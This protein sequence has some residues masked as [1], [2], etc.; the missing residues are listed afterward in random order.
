MAVNTPHLLTALG[1]VALVSV[2]APLAAYTFPS[3]VGADEA[4]VVLTGSM[5]PTID[6]GDVVFIEQVA[7]EDVEVGD[8]VTFHPHI[9]DERTFTH[10]VVEKAADEEGTRGIVLTTK[11]DANEDPDRTQVN[12]QMLVGKISHVLPAYGK[13]IYGIDNR[14]V[15]LLLVVLSILTVGFE[16]RNL[17]DDEEEP[18]GFDVIHQRPTSSTSAGRFEVVRR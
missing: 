18:E 8:I 12:E 17:L 10:R 1:L 13:I 4:L 9:T 5:Q 6:P 14:L 3:T 11:G 16:L 2:G 15:P 7:I